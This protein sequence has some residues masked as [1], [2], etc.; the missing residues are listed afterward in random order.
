MVKN[1]MK[2]A[3][4]RLGIEIRRKPGAEVP[5]KFGS[6]LNT[7]EA[8]V[9]SIAATTPCLEVAVVGA[10]D[11]K[12]NDPLY[13]ILSS[14]LWQRSRVMLFEPI[15]LLN[16]FLE[17]NFE[18]HPAA[19][20]VNVA[21]GAPGTGELFVVSKEHWPHLQPGYAKGWPPY[22]AP[23]GVTSSDRERVCDW[24]KTHSKGMIDVENAVV[25]QKIRFTDLVSARTALGL[26]TELDVLQIDAEGFDDNVLAYSN[27]DETRPRLIRFESAHLS[28][29]SIDRIQTILCSD[30][31]V[32]D[33]GR[34]AVCV[35]VADT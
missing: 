28:A 11:G 16:P 24:V 25:A 21:I 19:H 10:N 23:L 3:F 18:T 33:A 34:D 8:L 13:P 22:R 2:A 1:A 32:Y 31:H 6:P 35:R 27:L 30:Y 29:E 26:P 15:Q 4:G 20:I 12:H 14:H 9:L 17:K 5:S 7:Y